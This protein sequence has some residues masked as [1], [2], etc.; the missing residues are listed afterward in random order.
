[1]LKS[2]CYSILLFPLFSKAQVNIINRSLTDS[3]LNIVYI[4]V[5]NFLEIKGAKINGD[6]NVSASQGNI[7]KIG[8]HNFTLRVS[9]GDSIFITVEGKGRQILKKKFKCFELYDP[10]L[11]LGGIKDSAASINEILVTPFLR[12]FRED[13]FYKK[14]FMITSFSATFIGYDLD[15]LNT[16]ATGN[17]LT[18]EQVELIKKL[19]SGDQIFFNGIYAVGPDSRRRKLNPFTL[20]IR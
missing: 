11:R 19:R 7:T 6:I 16:H 8:I 2:I 18:Q 12:L 5:D 1:M 15:S 14:Q 17:L 10:V 9:P 4:E 13:C 3:S 20:T